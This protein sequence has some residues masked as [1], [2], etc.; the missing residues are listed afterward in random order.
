MVTAHLAILSLELT[1]MLVACLVI[2][3]KSTDT[4]LGGV[5]N[6]FLSQDFELKLHEVNLL[7]Q[8]DDVFVC[9]VDV[10]VLA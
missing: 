2:I 5:I 10:W 9:I 7:L 4:C 3:I 1:D 8:I 6:H